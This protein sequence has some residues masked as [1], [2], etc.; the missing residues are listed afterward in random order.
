MI[1]FHDHYGPKNLQRKQVTVQ[2]VETKGTVWLVWS[3]TNKKVSVLVLHFTLKCHP[4]L[5]LFLFLVSSQSN[6][7]G[8][9][10]EVDHYRLSP[11]QWPEG[12]DINSN[13]NLKNNSNVDVTKYSDPNPIWVPCVKVTKFTSSI[14]PV[15]SADDL[16]IKML[17][18]GSPTQ[19]SPFST[20]RLFREP[21]CS[22]NIIQSRKSS[23]ITS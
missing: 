17:I 16:P 4:Y 18:P 21:P 10:G 3:D 1:I 9:S 20:G 15:G 23:K 19:Q 11:S 7:G 22:A 2:R 14:Y 13:L 8:S 12:A 6:W 5:F